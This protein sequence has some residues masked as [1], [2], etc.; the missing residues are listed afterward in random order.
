M[1]LTEYNALNGTVVNSL[2]IPS[3]CQYER[4]GM[5]ITR[6]N[7]TATSAKLKIF[8]SS[9]DVWGGLSGIH[10]V[11]VDGDGG[12]RSGTGVKDT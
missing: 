5:W 4:S 9:Y 7:V 1:S 2:R 12:W 3:I 6:V 11:D 8:C 10:R